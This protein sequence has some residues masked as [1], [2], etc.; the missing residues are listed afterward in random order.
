M[1][2]ISK[3]A[4]EKELVLPKNLE[5]LNNLGGKYIILLTRSTLNKQ[6]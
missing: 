6:M 3:G 4:I 1:E 5:V 2:G